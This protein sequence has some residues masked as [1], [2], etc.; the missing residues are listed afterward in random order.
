MKQKL[1]KFQKQVIESSKLKNVEVTNQPQTIN[2]SSNQ[3]TD[4]EDTNQVP[5]RRAEDE[6]LDFVLRTEVKTLPHPP[7]TEAQQRRLARSLIKRDRDVGDL[8]AAFAK[9]Q[10]QRTEIEA[11]LAGMGST[12]LEAPPEPLPQP[13]TLGSHLTR[14]Q[15]IFAVS[16][17]ANTQLMKTMRDS[18]IAQALKLG[19]LVTDASIEL[20]PGQHP[21]QEVS[22]HADGS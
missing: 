8:R 5:P 22:S 2:N 3:T 19:F 7:V 17:Q 14:L 11:R 9:W 15:G 21:E 6:F 4:R 18:A 16:R 13:K 1:K 10:Q 20:S 12:S